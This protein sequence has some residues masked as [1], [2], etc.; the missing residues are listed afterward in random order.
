M[1]EESFNDKYNLDYQLK[2]MQRDELL[3]KKQLEA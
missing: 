2:K 1:S 3:L